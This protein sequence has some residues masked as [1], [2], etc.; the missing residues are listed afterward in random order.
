MKNFRPRTKPLTMTLLTK[1]NDRKDTSGMIN[2][3]SRTELIFGEEALEKLAN[4]RVAVFGV[5][6]VGGYAVEALARSGVGALDII[7]NDTVA[8]SNINRQIIALHSTIGEYKVDAAAKRIL[9]INPNIKLK[10]Y[11]T[12]FTPE[13]A[14]T[15]DFSE[16]DYVIDAIDTVVGKIELVM[17]AQ[18]AGTPIICSMGAG[19]KI[20]PTKFQVADIYK[21]SVC[22]LARVMRYELKKRRVKHLKCVFSTEEPITPRQSEEISGKRQTPGSCAFVPS[23]AGLI[24]AGE[25][26]KDIINA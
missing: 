14:D 4:A 7:D 24:I 23:V 8:L 2:Q 20:D 13:T 17:K 5:G 26:I 9:D 12:F 19:N 18:A 1:K 25:V 15:F 22:P 11:K 16:Y 6:G 21:T 10:A 3:F